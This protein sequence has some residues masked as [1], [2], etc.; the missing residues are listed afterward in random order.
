MQMLL[1]QSSAFFTHEYKRHHI[2]LITI[3]ITVSTLTKMLNEAKKKMSIKI[4]ADLATVKLVH[5]T[6]K[7]KRILSKVAKYF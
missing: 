4:Y 6:V 2:S 3:T 1:S 7:T 5:E